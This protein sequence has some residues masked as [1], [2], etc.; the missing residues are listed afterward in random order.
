MTALTLGKRNAITKRATFD[1]SKTVSSILLF[2]CAIKFIQRASVI[3]VPSLLSQSYRSPK[4]SKSEKLHSCRFAH[5]R[6]LQ[7]PPP[8]NPIAPSMLLRPY[9]NR[10]RY[11]YRCHYPGY[12][13]QSYFFALPHAILRH[14]YRGTTMPR[15][16]EPIDL[17]V[18]PRA[19][20][21]SFV[22]RN[23]EAS[24]RCGDERRR[25]ELPSRRPVA[26]D[27]ESHRVDLCNRCR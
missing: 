24:L 17:A 23:G 6:D 4:D 9:L 2:V 1:P 13:F 25:V 5:D 16:R 3:C 10:C 21:N 19:L 14:R 8:P 18:R 26:R 11:R 27:V 22:S 20:R 15:V 7:T 12:H